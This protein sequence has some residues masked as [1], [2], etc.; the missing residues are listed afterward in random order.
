MWEQVGKV[1]KLV[2]PIFFANAIDDGVEMA[3]RRLVQIFLCRRILSE[4]SLASSRS[5]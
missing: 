4:S 5:H 3:H 1:Y 2:E